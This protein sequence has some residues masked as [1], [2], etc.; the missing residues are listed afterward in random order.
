MKYALIGCGRISKNH[1]NAALSSNLQIALCDNNLSIINNLK[2][3][4]S[5]LEILYF[6]NYKEMLDVFQPQLVSIATPNASH[7]A[8]A[9]DCIRQGVNVIIEKPFTLSKNE[10]LELIEAR[11]RSGVKVAVC[12][13]NRFN[14]SIQK[15]KETIDR[16][17]LGKIHY[18]TAKVFW[19]RDNQYYDQDAWRGSMEHMDGALMNQSI[20]NIDLLLWL[21]NSTVKNVKSLRR[22]FVHPEIEMEDF[23]AALIEFENGSVGLFEAT[24]ATYPK[25]LEESLYIVCDKG[26]IKIGG[27]SVN[28]IEEWRVDGEIEPID[29]IKHKY[30]ESPENI[31][32]HGHKALYQDMIE[33][34][35]QNRDPYVTLEE[36]FRAVELILEIYGK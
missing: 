14:K 25:N 6:E 19:Y 12:H 20:H 5:H 16:G 28:Q 10:Y 30:S 13:Q 3:E 32:G 34:I 4:Y 15:A 11:N 1:I 17:Q 33:A 29:E 36:G 31:Y 35:E 21:M 7:S 9:L 26:T 22:N 23:G 24:T 2:N 18:I 27:Q 8:I